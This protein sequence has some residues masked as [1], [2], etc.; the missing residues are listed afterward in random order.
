MRS[1]GTNHSQGWSWITLPTYRGSRPWSGLNSSKYHTKYS[2]TLQERVAWLTLQPVTRRQLHRRLLR[3]MITLLDLAVDTLPTPG[4][5][6]YLNR[7]WSAHASA[8][9]SRHLRL[10]PR[11]SRFIQPQGRRWAWNVSFPD[12]QAPPWSYL[13]SCTYLRSTYSTYCIHFRLPKHLGQIVV[14]E[15]DNVRI[16][17]SSL[18]PESRHV[19]LRCGVRYTTAVLILMYQS[20]MCSF[21]LHFPTPNFQ[22]SLSR[23][24]AA[25]QT[26]LTWNRHK[27]YHRRWLLLAF[28]LHQTAMAFTHYNAA[29]CD[30]T[31]LTV[32]RETRMSNKWLYV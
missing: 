30:S 22:T 27:C 31:T 21:Y 14:E 13:R 15:V 5:T 20:R 9:S 2:I 1:I 25:L 32:V 29:T 16:F 11:P 7:K 17:S 4:K 23:Y 3:T 19:S 8:L 18:S 26:H 24:K 10:W 6:T 28:A 12:C